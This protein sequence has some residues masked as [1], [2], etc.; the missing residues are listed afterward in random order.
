MSLPM[1]REKQN[2][3]INV[4]TYL[5][6]MDSLSFKSDLQIKWNKTKAHIFITIMMNYILKHIIYFILIMD[7][8]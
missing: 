3:Q 7:Y 5:F 4:F 1:K 6:M 8:Q 2:P